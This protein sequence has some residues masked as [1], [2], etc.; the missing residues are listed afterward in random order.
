MMILAQ[1]VLEDGAVQRAQEAETPAC[2]E[3]VG[4][5]LLQG[6]G[7]VV[8][9]DLVDGVFQVLV[10]VLVGGEGG[11]ED[12]GLGLYKA[13]VGLD[14]LLRANRRVCVADLGFLR[15]L[16]ARVEVDV[17]DLARLEDR[18]GRLVRVHDAHFSNDVLQTRRKGAH[19]VAGP[20]LAIEDA[21]EQDDA[22]VY[23]IPRVDQEQAQRLAEVAHGGGDLV[24]DG[25][26]QGG[27]VEPRLGGH[28]HGVVGVQLEGLVHLVEHA[29]RVGVGQV[30]L[31]QDGHQGQAL[32]EGQVEVGDGL[33]L[34]ALAGVDEQQG[35]AARGVAAR[36]LGAEVDV[37][38]G[39]D[40]VQQ[41]VVALVVVDHG[42]RLRLDRDAALAL[43]VQL[44]EDLLVAA[45]L[46]R[47]RQLEQP[48]R[49]RALAMVHVGDNAEVAVPLDG[50][51]GDALLELALRAERLRVAPRVDG[52]RRDGEAEAEAEAAFKGGRAR[53]RCGRGR[54]QAVELR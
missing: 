33:G 52:R 42:A 1:A 6:H 46:D 11:D 47:A 29:R 9:D 54:G 53:R 32:R 15:A 18:L 38:G 31:V 19:R 34:H 25:G 41:V 27:D 14:E 35:A 10:V 8:E 39:V 49:Q 45:G 40:E 28:E 24:D 17:A 5:L 7:A 51:R 44:V 16:H 2:A 36:D 12:H 26:Q 48:V 30:D 22:L 3:G 50:D 43:H 4:G 37:A 23:V 13:R 21:H 20:H